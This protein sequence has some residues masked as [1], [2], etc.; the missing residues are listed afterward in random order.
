[1]TVG[2]P[3]GPPGRLWC[4]AWVLVLPDP[5]LRVVPHG[6][7]P[8]CRAVEEGNTAAVC[9]TEALSQGVRR[10]M[11]RCSG[12]AQCGTQRATKRATAISPTTA[13][14]AHRL[15][16]PTAILESRWL[17]RERER[18][19]PTINAAETEAVALTL[20]ELADT[21]PTTAHVHVHIGNTSALASMKQRLSRSVAITAE[22]R[23]RLPPVDRY[24][25]SS[26]HITS[27][28]GVADAPSRVAGGGLDSPT[29]RA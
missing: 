5:P 17:E 3:E 4:A 24:E 8:H 16:K 19:F 11:R 14:G 23:T 18:E 6:G 9:D 15:T 7:R 2:G 27:E 25:L 22:L 21:L 13:V 1:M 28:E 12:G 29:D 10:E 26:S 20:S